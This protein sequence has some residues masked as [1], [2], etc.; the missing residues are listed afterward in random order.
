M[1]MQERVMRPLIKIIGVLLVL[2]VGVAIMGYFM[3]NPVEATKVEN[4]V[5]E[6]RVEFADLNSGEYRV[7]LSAQGQ[8]EPVIQTIIISEVAGAIDYISPKLKAGGRFSKGEKMLK[9]SSADYQAQLAQ[10]NASVAEAE[11]KIVQEEARAV[12]AMRDWKKLGR[13]GNPGKLVTREPQLKS[14]R[15]NLEAAKA[16]AVQAQRDLAKTEVNAPYDCMVGAASVDAGGYL[17][18]GGRVAEVYTA[19]KVQVRLPL[20][21]ED[22]SFLPQDLVGSKAVVRAEVGRGSKDW[23]GKVVRTEGRIDRATHTMMIVVEVHE[24][25]GDGMFKLP[26]TGL[27]VKGS[28]EGE[29]FDSAV[30]VPREAL[31]SDDAV[32]L[33]DESNRLQVREVKV[34]RS[35]RDYVIV[36][37]GLSGGDR[38]ITSPIELPVN[39]MKVEPV[40][41]NSNQL[42]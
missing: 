25:D 34:V 7:E 17:P 12:Q 28:F 24:A 8:V 20:S 26:P 35:E 18:R 16:N 32:W 33:L 23:F 4:E 37:D 39:G 31:R 42:N 27:F 15:A 9:V 22:V 13:G 3:G 30:K 11:F 41:P 2:G 10:A 21:L 6:P 5:F 29:V 1:S 19:D 14:A 40:E 36:T 38:V